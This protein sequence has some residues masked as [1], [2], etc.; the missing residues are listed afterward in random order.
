MLVNSIK[1][2]ALYPSTA[3]KSILNNKIASLLAI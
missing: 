1:D 3:F 2:P